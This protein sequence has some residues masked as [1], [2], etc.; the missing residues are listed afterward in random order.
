[1]R[2]LEEDDQVHRLRLGADRLGRAE[3]HHHLV[4]GAQLDPGLVG[5]DAVDQDV[6]VLDQALG[7]RPAQLRDP[8]GD[9][10][11]EPLPG[12]TLLLGDERPLFYQIF[13]LTCPLDF[14]R[15]STMARS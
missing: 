9:E 13:D 4:A 8:R 15:T 3:E 6:A 2:V 7:L 1:V 11:V 10:D 12:P 14:T 5:L